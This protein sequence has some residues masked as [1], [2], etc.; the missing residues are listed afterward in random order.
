MKAEEYE[1]KFTKGYQEAFG[2][3]ICGHCL[4]V[5]VS[6]QVSACVMF[7]IVYFRHAVCHISIIFQKSY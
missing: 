6:S 1:E 4:N 7:Q 3:G 5:V 2:N